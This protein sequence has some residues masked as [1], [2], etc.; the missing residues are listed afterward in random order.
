MTA[1]MVVVVMV[2]G[3]MVAMMVVMVV[4]M[5]VVTPFSFVFFF[6]GFHGLLACPARRGPFLSDRLVLMPLSR[7]PCARENRDLSYGQRFSPMRADSNERKA[8]CC[9]GFCSV[10]GWQIDAN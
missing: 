3:V 4:V 8:P 2:V 10:G 9:C 5:V 7:R 6:L 1:V